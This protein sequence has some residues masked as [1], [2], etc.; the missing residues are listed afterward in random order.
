MNKHPEHPPIGYRHHSE[1]R[2]LDTRRLPSAPPRPGSVAPATRPTAPH[3][4]QEKSMNKTQRVREQL[5][6]MA[7]NGQPAVTSRALAD[8]L[9]DIDNG[10]VSALLRTLVKA[11]NTPE[12]RTGKN[13]N[14]QVMW[15]WEDSLAGAASTPPATDNTET[16]IPAAPPVPQAP[17]PDPLVARIRQM[18]RP[19]IPHAQLHADRLRAI[20]ELPIIDA[21]I[22]L[23]L[24]ELAGLIEDHADHEGH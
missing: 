18:L 10:T 1:F 21:E 22:A 6:A 2:D 12:L 20:A 4:A 24:E 8:A 16:E 23:W 7:G 15:W 14:G 5:Q 11:G 19:G 9:G 17:G 3:A 13:K